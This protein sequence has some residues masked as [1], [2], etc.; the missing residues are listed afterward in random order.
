MMMKWRDGWVPPNEKCDAEVEESFE[1]SPWAQQSNAVE[2]Y[3]PD[4]D[5]RWMKYEMMKS[6]LDC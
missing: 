4:V 2:R 6:C 1:Y 5:E 3:T